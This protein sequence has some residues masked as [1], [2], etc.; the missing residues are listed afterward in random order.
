MLTNFFVQNRNALLGGL[1]T[2]IFVGLGALFL[3]D[4]SGYEARQLIES[5]LP[6]IQYVVQYDYIG[7]GNHSCVTIN[8]VG[9]QLCDRF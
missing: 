9:H 1:A 7:V 4:I 3:G 6:G 8:I 5:S 2:T